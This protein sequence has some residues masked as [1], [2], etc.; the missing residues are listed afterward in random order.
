MSD[1]EGNTPRPPRYNLGGLQSFIPLQDEQPRTPS[2]LQRIPSLKPNRSSSNLF[3]LP[4]RRMRGLS[5]S[6]DE[7]I[8]PP[9]EGSYMGPRRPTIKHA[10]TAFDNRDL[11]EERRMS[12]AV[13]VLMTP[14][15]RS[16]RLIGNSNP[17][18]RWQR[19]YKTQEQLNEYS[20]PLRKYYER[21]NFSTLR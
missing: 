7:S 2:R 21:T 4:S 17:R 20:K 18:Y 1:S 14:Q 19:Y 10:A 16:M 11:N 5:I 15:M 3:T 9:S 8:E 6:D 13:E 12:H